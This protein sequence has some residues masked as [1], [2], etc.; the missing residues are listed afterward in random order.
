MV[1]KRSLKKISHFSDIVSFNQ[2]QRYSANCKQKKK[3]REFLLIINFR[4]K[5]TS[6]PLIYINQIEA[7]QQLVVIITTKKN[8]TQ[9]T[10]S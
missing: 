3:K 9:D 8:P 5:K 6:I 4:L 7:K 10:M 1:F 2:M